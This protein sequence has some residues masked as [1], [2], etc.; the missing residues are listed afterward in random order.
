MTK[1]TRFVTRYAQGA[2]AQLSAP[3]RIITLANDRAAAR[4]RHDWPLA[5]G[6]KVEI[7]SGGWKVIDHGLGFELLPARPDDIVQDGETIYGSVASVP[8]RLTEPSSAA[9]SLV[10][11]PGPRRTPP[12]PV[13]AAIASSTGAGHQVL[14]VGSRDV[15][16]KA[17]ADEVIRT[18][19]PLSAGDALQAA[20]LRATGELIVII[21]SDRIPA[22]DVLAPLREALSDPSVAAAGSD[23][24]LSTDLRR[25]A[26]ASSG[27]VT[28]LRSGCYAF[29][30]PD[31]RDRGP[32]EP[33]LRLPDSAAAWWTL[34]LR[35][36][37]PD[38]EPRRAVALDLPIGPRPD[39]T[40]SAAEDSRLARRD[41]YRIADLLG[42]RTWLAS[43]EPPRGR[44]IGDRA[45]DD[46]D[47]DDG[48]ERRDTGHP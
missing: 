29:R 21:D 39:A 33:R 4:A 10:V 44:V 28:A 25:Y 1:G 13:L 26:P 41:A 15:P 17:P 30:R 34:V 8:S 37:G 16:V 43:E 36:E 7:E 18:V 14:A 11:V 32:I 38:A 5:D 2:M 27:D 22:G 24:L 45:D 20:L 35:D 40:T 47:D 46:H 19:E 23:G 3:P 12:D 31:G 48:E 42:E 6:L 9:I